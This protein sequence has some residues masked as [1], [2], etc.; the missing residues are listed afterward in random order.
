MRIMLKKIKRIFYRGM[1]NKD[2]S[3]EQLQKM[4]LS[5][6]CILID[7]R[8]HQEYAEEHLPGAVLI[9]VY[10]NFTKNVA[11]MVPNKKQTIIV[12]CSSGSRSKQAQQELETAG[13][14]NVY[15]LSGGLDSI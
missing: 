7:V 6:N 3:Y 4:L 14:E 11:K 2:I 13:Y 15:N 1:N 9:S 8:S 10:E 12:Y 5:K